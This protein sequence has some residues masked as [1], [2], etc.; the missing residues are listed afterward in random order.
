MTMATGSAS[1]NYTIDLTRE[2]TLRRLEKLAWFMDSSIRIPGTSRTVGADGFL[3]LVPGIG[4]FA[5]TGISAYVLLEAFRHGVPPGAMVRMGGNLLADTV[6][7]SIPVAGFVFDLA[8]KANQR[9][10]RILREHLEGGQT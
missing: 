5:G 3:S 4:S 8:F 1:P 2:G 6:M 7:G 9:N 10:M